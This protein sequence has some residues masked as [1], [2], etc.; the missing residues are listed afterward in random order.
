MF[1]SLSCFNAVNW[2]SNTMLN[3]NGRSGHS[4]L[5][6]EF[7]S[8]AIIFPPVSINRLWFSVNSFS[9]VELRHLH[10]FLVRVFIKNGCSILSNV[11]SESIKMT[12]FLLMWCVSHW[13]ICL[14]GTIIVTLEWIQLGDDIWSFPSIARSGLLIFCWGLLHLYSSKILGYNFW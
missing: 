11:F 1:I 3:R 4:N 8:K 12:V 6:S 2:T 14:C 13:L 5:I 7:S 10:T 9:Y